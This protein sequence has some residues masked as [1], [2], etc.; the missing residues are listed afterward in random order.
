MLPFAHDTRFTGPVVLGSLP[1]VPGLSA[2][3]GKK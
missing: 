1:P 2:K 3:S